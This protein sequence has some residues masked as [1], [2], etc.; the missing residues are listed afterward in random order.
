MLNFMLYE[1]LILG[2]FHIFRCI[3]GEEI[4][5]EDFTPERH[6][7]VYFESFCGAG[8]RGRNGFG[9]GVGHGHGLG[10]GLGLSKFTSVSYEVS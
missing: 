8:L 2:C 4:I 10:L 5:G 7:C 1:R 9:E 3:F 6:C